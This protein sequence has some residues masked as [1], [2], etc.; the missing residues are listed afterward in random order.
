MQRCTSLI[1][2]G[3][4][5]Q[6]MIPTQFD[7]IQCK[8]IKSEFTRMSSSPFSSMYCLSSPSALSPN[9]FPPLPSRLCT[10]FPPLPL[11]PLIL[12]LLSLLVTVLYCTVLYCTVLY[13]T[14]Q[15]CVLHQ[16]SKSPLNRNISFLCLN[17]TA[18]NN[19]YYFIFVEH[20]SRKSRKVLFVLTS[21]K[22]VRSA[23]AYF[24][25]LSRHHPYIILILMYTN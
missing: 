18:E 4:V 9:S 15:Y 6:V 20:A 24:L 7:A 3:A 12:F 2:C 22:T 14:V 11:Y 23:D 13:C 8:G 21:T 16:L 19:V 1:H 25:I 10:V 5:R 17:V